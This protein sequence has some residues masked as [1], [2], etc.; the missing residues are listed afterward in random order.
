MMSAAMMCV[1]ASTRVSLLIFTHFIMSSALSP[2]APTTARNAAPLSPLAPPSPAPSARSPG[3]ATTS[4]SNAST[5]LKSPSLHTSPGTS[6]R[7]TPKVRARDLLRKHY[8]LGQPGPPAPLPGRTNDPMDLGMSDINCQTWCL[9][10]A[11]DST[12]FD[13]RTYY[14]Q[15]ITTSPLVALIKHEN[16][17]LS[18]MYTKTRP[19]RRASSCPQKFGNS[20]ASDNHWF[21]T[22]TTNL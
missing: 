12:A 7:T 6:G 17:L 9:R 21:I 8:G 18:G 10:T 3:P 5:P 20:T 22:I 14:D 11:T 1:G 15:L 19:I 16:E 13:A 4:F 2:R